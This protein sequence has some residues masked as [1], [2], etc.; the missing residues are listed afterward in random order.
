MTLPNGGPVK[1]EEL[2]RGA[3]ISGVLPTSPVAVID[4]Q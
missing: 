3:R 1:L 4:V 2:E